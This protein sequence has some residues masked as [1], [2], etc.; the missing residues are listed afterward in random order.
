MYS[1]HLL[2]SCWL[3]YFLHEMG[4]STV[5]PSQLKGLF[6]IINCLLPLL[7]PFLY[8]EFLLIMSSTLSQVSSLK[9]VSCE[10]LMC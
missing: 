9:Y 4:P 8:Q 5:I 7:W 2:E 10:M 1:T 6:Q 3:A